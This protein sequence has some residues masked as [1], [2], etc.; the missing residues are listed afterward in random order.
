MEKATFEFCAGKARASGLEVYADS[1]CTRHLA[2]MTSSSRC[3]RTLPSLFVARRQAR[4]ERTFR[5][6]LLAVP[7]YFRARPFSQFVVF[8]AIRAS[9]RFVRS[10]DARYSTLRS[11]FY[12]R[13]APKT[14]AKPRFPRFSRSIDFEQRADDFLD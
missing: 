12:R 5:K 2:R 9:F 8:R 1:H 10:S 14:P 6:G 11:V 13:F 7:R 4:R 3:P